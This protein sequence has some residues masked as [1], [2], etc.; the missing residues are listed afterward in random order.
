MLL[1]AKELLHSSVKARDGAIGDVKDAYFD[2]QYWTVR[3]LV[4]EAGTLLKSRQVLLSPEAINRAEWPETTGVRLIAVDLNHE[5]V[6]NSPAVDAHKPVSRQEEEELRR[7]Y[8][9]P[10]YWGS[11]AAYGGVF[12][13]G[14]AFA[15][16]AAVA[17]P[18]ASV[19][20]AQ[21]AGHGGAP[22]PAQPR[23]DPHLRS[24]REVAGYAIS[25]TDGEIGH[26]EDFLVH[27]R[28]WR[29]AYLVVDTRNWWPGK[30]VIV[31]PEWVQDI[32]W[33]DASVRFEVTRATI[34]QA[35]EYVADGPLTPEY[36]AALHAYYHRSPYAES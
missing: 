22:A 3:Y 18:V 12:P 21:A 14:G 4:V 1:K 35:P 23:G 19:A 13:A 5:Q 6:R 30:K 33:T 25:A 34:K 7:Y 2:D 9:W 26:V 15:G 36:L 29:I 24:M 28:S 32:S 27:D 8:G 20:A 11:S 16:P 17:D 31:A 10:L